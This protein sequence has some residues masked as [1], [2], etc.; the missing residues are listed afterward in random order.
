MR[1]LLFIFFS[2]FLT[3]CYYAPN[4]KETTEHPEN[5]PWNSFTNK[6]FEDAKAQKKF[7]LL[8]IGA[9]WCHWC[10]VMEDSTYSDSQVQKYM[11]ENFVLAKEDQDSRPDLFTK[12]RSYGWPAIILFDENANEI[13]KLR[14][15][16]ERTKFLSMIQNAR[17]NPTAII[18][19]EQEKIKSENPDSLNSSQLLRIFHSKVDFEKGSMKT[20]KKSL[21]APSIEMA[22]TFSCESD[23]LKNWLKTSIINSYQLIDPVWGGA[24][25]YATHYDWK[26][27]HFERLLRIQAEHIINFCRYG[28]INNDSV[29]IQKA[30]FI[31]D[32]CNEFLSLDPPLF[33]NSQDADYKKGIESTS[34]YG[35]SDEDR[36]KLGVP[37]THEVQFVKE[38]AM[39][40]K[41]LI[42]L[43]ASTGNEKYYVRAEK[44][45]AK[46]RSDFKS[47][48]GLYKRSSKDEIIFSLDDNL[49]MLDALILAN[50]V[51]GSPIF[52]DEA[53][54]LAQAIMLS[55][56][57]E[58]G[59]LNSVSGDLTLKPDV[60][61][62]SNM[63]AAFSIHHLGHILKNDSLKLNALSISNTI[64]TG[65]ADYSEFFIPFRLLKINYLD[66][67]P[68]HAVLLFS[69]SGTQL[70]TDMIKEL[71]ALGNPNLIIEHVNL[72]K[73]TPEQEILYGSA[74]PGTLFICNSSFCSS[75]IKKTEDIRSVL[76]PENKKTILPEQYGF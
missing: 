24:F 22:V 19:G 74:E 64:L 48:N 2:V 8:H 3:A 11:L 72:N 62:S 27:A 26:D 18:E 20:F 69:E 59:T 10:H 51:S 12:Y 33:N 5:L 57:N 14:G 53:E 47:K 58:N 40:A 28:N 76:V 23:S 60:L 70:E 1:Q 25:Q 30:E 38:N 56:M 15:Y 65:S 46:L 50:Q 52:I 31:Y 45:L 44:I 41:A 68:L 42:L 35:L 37:I 55:F 54:K 43:W 16:Q 4:K 7:V 39:M 66:T 61:A 67:E 13:L 21:F 6:V 63:S 17:E 34:Y 71:V 29:A 36:R 9:Q 49:A 73:L 32:Y 75:P